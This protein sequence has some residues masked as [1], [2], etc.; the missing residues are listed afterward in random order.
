MGKL[1]FINMPGEF[2]SPDNG[3]AISTIIH[4]MR[5][6]LKNK[7]FESIV[8]TREP[9]T[10]NYDEE[11]IITLKRQFEEMEPVKKLFYC[12]ENKI[13]RFNRPAYGL[14]LREVKKALIKSLDPEDTLI[15]FNDLIFPYYISKFFPKTIVLSW[16]QNEC[17]PIPKY[18]NPSIITKTYF[19]TCSDYIRKWSIKH[20]GLSPERVHTVHSGVDLNIFSPRVN[21]SKIDRTN[22]IRL[23]YVGR[24]D[25]NK[26]PDIAVNVTARLQR[27][28][29]PVEISVA[30]DVWFYK[31]KTDE[32]DS[33]S[34][35]LGKLIAKVNGNCLGHLNRSEIADVFRSHDI[36]FVLSRSNEPFALVALEAMAS[37]CAVI[38]S[39]RGGLPES[40]GGAAILVNPDNEIEVVDATRRLV[41]DRTQLQKYKNM[42]LQRASR[43]GWT[44][45]ASR[46]TTLL[47]E[48]QTMNINKPNSN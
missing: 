36:T 29:F 28:G 1:I 7:G 14:Y 32:N 25:R 22:P 24:I 16:L 33:F 8:I 39:N 41:S 11:G 43:A 19:L 3:G 4:N 10:K 27:E 40:C 45:A 26:G 34:H 35:E 17:A 9:L 37:G 15:C 38:A 20:H 2:Y 23:L 6:T 5:N 13:R 31:R 46:F 44:L 18:T 48:I 47:H 12:I 42:A 30:G 21:S